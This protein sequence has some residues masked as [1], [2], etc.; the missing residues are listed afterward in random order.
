MSRP[1]L[2]ISLGT[3]F[4]WASNA[5]AQQEINFS[6][7]GEPG[8]LYDRSAQEFAKRANERLGDKARVTV[9]ASSQ[10]GGDFE[11]MK[12][13]KLGTLDLGL[14]SSVMSSYLPSFGIFEMP[15]LVKDRA[16]MARIRD[17]IVLP[18]LAPAVKKVGYQIV[19]V[20]EN[21]FRHITNSKR[22]IVKP[23]DL[24]GL[25]LRVPQGGWRVKM[26]QAYGVNPTPLAYSEV[27]LALQ[28]GA[29]DG[30]ENPLAQIYPGKLYEVQKFLSLSGHVYSPAYLM[31][32]KNWESMSPEIRKIVSEEAVAMQPIAAR[33][34]TDLDQEFLKKLKD[35]GMVVNDVDQD[36]FAKAS[37]KIYQEFATEVPEAK[38]LLNK[39][40]GLGK[41]S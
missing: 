26:F 20:W 6:H 41:S 4:L 23:D 36:A 21:G 5:S 18:I 7:A 15:H 22:P 2:L 14:P 31:A 3:L 16:H 28:T 9:Y 1:T 39:A 17:E 13:L 25:N 30:Q 24:S 11:I 8:S 12:K 33:L 19:A 29:M 10:L 34:G 38:M 35:A 27:Y 32:G 40:M 37:E